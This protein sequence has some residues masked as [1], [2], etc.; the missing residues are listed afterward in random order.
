MY[1]QTCSKPLEHLASAFF[2]KTCTSLLYFKE[3]ITPKV[4][5]LVLYVQF[6]TQ[7]CKM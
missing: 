5:K 1:I 2:K 4:H 7:T 6:H 3:L